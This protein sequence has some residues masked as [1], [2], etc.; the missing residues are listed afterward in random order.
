VTVISRIDDGPPQRLT[1]VVTMRGNLD[2]YP[3]TDPGVGEWYPQPFYNTVRFGSQK[4]LDKVRNAIRD[5]GVPMTIGGIFFDHVLEVQ[6]KHS[7][8]ESEN[9]AKKQ[10]TGIYYLTDSSLP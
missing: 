2:D 5:F 6:I 3:R 1:K 9:G 7:A 8:F 10:Q 4:E